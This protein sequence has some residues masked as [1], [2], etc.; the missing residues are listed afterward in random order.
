MN[1]KTYSHTH[2]CTYPQ[3]QFDPIS[4]SVFWFI[5]L[6]V[7]PSCKEGNLNVDECLILVHQQ[8]LNDSVKNVLDS[9]MLDAAILL[10][11]IVE[12]SNSVCIVIHVILYMYCV[13]S[14]MYSHVHADIN[15]IAHFSS[16][17][18]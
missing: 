5:S 9:C 17:R 12:Y 8:L 15:I 7:P 13:C 1:T 10:A 14:Y 4:Y 11:S 3:L 18:A 16:P 6:L 2:T